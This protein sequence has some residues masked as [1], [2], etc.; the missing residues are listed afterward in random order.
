MRHPA[1]LFAATPLLARL[2]ALAGA[3]LLSLGAAF[4]Q[5]AGQE[6]G[7]AP[8]KDPN[9]IIQTHV[10]S[11]FG[12]A[13]YNEPFDVLPYVNPDAPKGGEI[14][15]AALGTFDSMNPYSRKGRAG[16]LSTIMYERILED[17]ADDPYGTYCLL[18]TSMEFPET[19][20]WVIFHLRED[21]TFSDGTPATAHDIVFTVDL[22]LEQALPSF[23]EAVKQLYE[24][25]EA[26]DDHTVKFTFK[27]GI[28]RKTLIVQAGATPMWSQ[29][30][31]EE[32]GARLDEGR[33]ETGPGTGPYM[34]GE[35]DVNRRIVYERNPDYWGADLPINKGR[36]NFDRIRVEYFGDANAA[37]EGF[38]AGAYTFRQETSSLIWATGY[39]FPAVE[40][41]Y[42]VKTA[43]PNGLIPAANGFV[44][45]LRRE[46]WQD[47]RVREAL[48]L[49]FNFQ[50]TND[51]LQYGLFKQRQSFWENSDLAATGVAEGAELA[52]LEGLGDKVDPAI[53]TE[54]AFT[55]PA[56]SD[57]QLDRGALRKAAALLD[58]AG[59]VAGDDGIRR[60]DAGEVL[61][62]EI[63]GDTS[64]APTFGRIIVPYVENLRTLGVDATYERV[65]PA[66]FT[67]RSRAFDYDMVYDGYSNGFEEGIGI[68]QKYGSEDA[69]YSTFN[70]AGYSSPAVDA[71]ID[72]VIEAETLE[73]MQT[74][75]T[76]I[77]RVMRWER[78]MVPSWYNDEYWVAYYDMF[79]HPDPLPPYDLGYLDLW[80]YDAEKAQALREAGAL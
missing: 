77:D 72:K 58:E 59:W 37:L 4:A 67:N 11:T 30:W 3:G 39:D 78:Y 10:Y 43:I 54:E 46:R 64:S 25:V 75:V 29:K 74:A 31:Y 24:K 47:P 17:T 15:I 60:N 61:Q 63:L 21:I 2:A 1:R 44:F 49:M 13:K 50:W 16:A 9:K 12:D 18:C 80:W 28:P 71:L 6:A 22:L 70:P 38:K 26:L 32:S 20:D 7:A 62:L 69:E 79:G 35:I 76:A 55:F 53:L 65:D 73:Q 48:G 56:G 36:Y 68:A 40:K 41:G 5:E 23:R 14:A 51:S 33:L 42:V 45:N 19:E 34:V 66:Q 52:L 27:E 8:A 57:R